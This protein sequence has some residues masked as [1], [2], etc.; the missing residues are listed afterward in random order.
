MALVKHPPET[1]LLELL[2][3]QEF[4]KLMDQPEFLALIRAAND[5]YVPWDKF[6]WHP[7]PDGVRVED[8]WTYLRFTRRGQERNS[9]FFNEHDIAFTYSLPDC[10][11]RALNEVDRWSGDSIGSD[12]PAGLPETEWYVISAL[13]EE[14]IAS[15]QL[16]GAATTRRVAK[17]MLRT[18]RKPRDRAE[19]MIFNNWNTIQYLRENRKMKLTPT[20]LCEIHAMIT[21]KTLEHSEDAGRIRLKDDVTVNYHDE[22]IHTPPPAALLPGRMQKFCDFANNDDPNHWIHPVVKACMLHFWI[23][24]D[25]PFVDGN[26][27]TARAIFYW[28]MLSRGYRLFEFL[29]ISRFFLKAPVSYAKAYLYTE[30]DKGDLTYFIK[31]NLKIIQ[32]AF[33]DLHHYLR[34]KQQEL[35]DVNAL[36]RNHPG[37]N[38]RQRR[39]LAHVVRHVNEEHTFRSYETSHKVVYQT[40]RTDLLDLVNRGLL[41]ME[42]RGKAFVFLPVRDLVQRLGDA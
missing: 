40:A 29:S 12:K 3:N 9:P 26:G 24:Y 23:G 6:R 33:K 13:M 5:E 34:R 36:L 30:T 32:L 31:Y 11:L 38:F 8:A 7:M 20:V 2:S 19:K 39:F 21:D 14:A 25:H 28:Y 18:G 10:V 17:E 15:S 4:G 35:S 41:N 42:K 16:E 27:R 22:V 1:K 37:L